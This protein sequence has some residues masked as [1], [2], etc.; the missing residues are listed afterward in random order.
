MCTH[1]SLWFNITLLRVKTF[2]TCLGVRLIHVHHRITY[3]KNDLH[4]TKIIGNTVAITSKTS[5][6]S[7]HRC[8]FCKC[9]AFPSANAAY[10]HARKT[11][12]DHDGKF[13]CPHC[14][15]HYRT[16]SSFALHV[17]A[18]HLGLATW[19][20][21][22][23]DT[24]C[25]SVSI[26]R[27]HVR[28]THLDEFTAINRELSMDSVYMR[29]GELECRDAAVRM[30][31]E[32]HK[33]LVGLSD[34]VI[35]PS[36]VS[37]SDSDDIEE[38]IVLEDETDDE[39]EQTHRENKREKVTVDDVFAAAREVT[40]AYYGM[41]SLAYVHAQM[42]AFVDLYNKVHPGPLQI[43]PIAS[44]LA[45]TSRG[46]VGPTLMCMAKHAIARISGGDTKRTNLR[47]S[48]ADSHVQQSK[49]R[50]RPRPSIN[51]ATSPL[52]VIDTYTPP[53]TVIRTR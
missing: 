35:N 39:M 30:H 2:A 25:A 33:H 18:S 29:C 40:D 23:C 42:I 19:S 12:A 49:S 47:A 32:V 48:V 37:P 13:Q 15:K 9:N 31:E 8:L 10:E 7:G 43:I 44:V 21:K 4:T 51:N 5:I 6:M 17:A 20:C 38:Y 52:F 34:A 45:Q 26:F 24:A 36:C 28:E 53:G 46:V 41:K 3:N 14:A 11:H 16:L 27:N 1:S 50:K 22:I